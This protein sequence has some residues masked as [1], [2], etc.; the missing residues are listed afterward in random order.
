MSHY[1][2]LNDL[3]DILLGAHL[4]AS[5]GGGAM[6][7]GEQLIKEI[8]EHYPPGAVKVPFIDPI[9]VE[10][11]AQI[12]VMAAM[13][14]PLSFLEMG[15]G[16]S[17][18]RAFKAHQKAIANISSNSEF[19]FNHLVPIESGV[20]AHAMC[21][22]VAA[23]LNLPI[24]DGDGGGRAFP[25]LQMA[26]FASTLK[27]DPVRLSPAVLCSEESYDEMGTTITFEQ[28]SPATLD[29]LTRA[30]ISCG[31]GFENRASLSCFA[32]DG[33]TLRSPN[34]LVRNTLS[35]ARAT[36]SAIREANA[37]GYNP[38]D[39]VLNDTGGSLLFQGTLQDVST[40]TSNGFDLLTVTLNNCSERVVVIA[41]NEN[42]IV[43][44]DN[45]HQPLAMAPDIISYMTPEGKV[46]GNT[47]LSDLF[48]KGERPDI[49]LLGIPAPE[50]IINSYFIEQFQQVFRKIGYFGDFA[51]LA[52]LSKKG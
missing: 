15:F 10:D 11:N 12:A 4:F 28:K 9:K 8:V 25:S 44:N 3:Q 33:K 47:E 18:V 36:G 48:R 52:T 38:I 45:H 5:G 41:K 20:I 40:H 16:E 31:V 34:K 43:W 7:N 21:L 6:E 46:L 1:F 42:M 17:P 39:V 35:R 19:E 32:M 13:G 26:T 27:G 22:N 24:V 2:D 30:I 37:Y 50:A 51:S 14:A 49:C 23:Q 29:Q